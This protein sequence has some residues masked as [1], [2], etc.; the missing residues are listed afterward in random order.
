[1]SLVMSLLQEDGVAAR[2]ELERRAVWNVEARVAARERD[3]A[4]HVLLEL[5][6]EPA[7]AAAALGRRFVAARARVVVVPHG[8]ASR[9]PL[10]RQVA[11]RVRAVG[12]EAR[13]GERGVGDVGR[14]DLER[15]GREVRLQRAL[16]RD[17]EPVPWAEERARAR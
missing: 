15:D 6:R 5:V 14:D 8:E 7:A 11:D 1:M 4:A 12:R 13:L 2:D 16:P 9:D 17:G 3:A 10:D